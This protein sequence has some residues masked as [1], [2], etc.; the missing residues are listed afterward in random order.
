M[1]LLFVHE[2]LGGWGG[3][4]ANLLLTASQLEA[5]G[6]RLGLAQR[7]LTGAQPQGW[8]RSFEDSFELPEG[9]EAAERVAGIV[10]DW[11]P[12]VLFCHNLADLAVLQ[13]LLDSG[14]PLVRLVHD[15]RMYCLRGYKYN[16]FTRHICT[17]PASAFCVFPCLATLARNRSGRGWPLQWAS[18]RAKQAELRLNRQCAR[19]VVFSEYMRQELIRNQFDPG[20]VV[21]HRPILDAEPA[22]PSTNYSE[23]NLIVY[24]GQILR[25]KGVDLLLRALARVQ[26]PFECRLFGEGNYRAYCERLSRRLGLAERVHFAGA[27]SREELRRHCLEATVLAVSSVWPEPFG[28]VGP[29]GMRYGLPVV[30]FDAGAVREWLQD[31]VNGYL[32]AWKDV[33]SFALRLEALLRDKTLARRLGSQARQWVLQDFDAEPQVEA[34]ERL[35]AQV[36]LSKATG[37]E[38]LRFSSRDL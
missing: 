20:R 3:A 17:R 11:A 6:H 7:R 24:A 33:A 15:H 16:C 38:A 13:G 2:R 27:V 8:G 12:D 28:L 5:R 22:P 29:E 21:V 25:G 30:A 18:Y 36:S 34:L 23:R 10:A 1:R 4:E 19:L 9:D 35:F 32:V 31:G 26:G 14:V 37:I